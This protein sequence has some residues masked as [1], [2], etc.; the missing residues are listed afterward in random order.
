[1]SQKG[2]SSPKLNVA[3]FARFVSKFDFLSAFVLVSEYES[4]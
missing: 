4:C 3:R 2:Y 1:M